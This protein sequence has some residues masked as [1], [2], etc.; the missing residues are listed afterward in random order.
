MPYKT[1]KPFTS[2]VEQFWQWPCYLSAKPQGSRREGWKHE[3]SLCIS[4][5]KVETETGD[6]GGLQ[7]H[8][9]SMQEQGFGSQRP[10]EFESE[11]GHKG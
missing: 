11:E 6:L 3:V 2:L 4:I 8:C 10:P 7:R 1:A 9:L 5:K